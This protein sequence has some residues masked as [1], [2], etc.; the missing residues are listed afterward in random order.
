[1]KSFDIKKYI[2]LILGLIALTIGLVYYFSIE[3][4]NSKDQS[5]Q[6]QSVLQETILKTL[7]KSDTEIKQ[8]SDKIISNK[9]NTFEQLQL[10]TSYP[11]F[12]FK[13][14]DINQQ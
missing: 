8:V 7:K 4:V 10:K 1:M 6:Y 3:K 13:N 11:Y 12:V 2:F 9:N 5:S 14:N